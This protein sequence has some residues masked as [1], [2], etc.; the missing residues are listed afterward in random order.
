[1]ATE[2]AVSQKRA[3]ASRCLGAMG[4]RVLRAST[5]CFSTLVLASCLPGVGAQM[6]AGR[7][8]GDGQV[9]PQQGRVVIASSLNASPRAGAAAGVVEEKRTP[10]AGQGEPS[11]EATSDV[12]NEKIRRAFISVSSDGGTLPANSAASAVVT[13]SSSE[14]QQPAA[15]QHGNTRHVMGSSDTPP[16]P[17]AAAPAAAAAAGALAG[18]PP[19]VT[20]S[21]KTANQANPE[22]SK[23]LTNVMSQ[24]GAPICAPVCVCVCVIVCVRVWVLNPSIHEAINFYDSLYVI[25]SHRAEGTISGRQRPCIA[26]TCWQTPCT[27]CGFARDISLAR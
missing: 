21:A 22:A 1:M 5:L 4:R 17:V 14:L 11:R 12:V 10:L 20:A 3:R 6:L 23:N 9:A 24:I 15:E 7:P 8:P 27:W 13:T 16:P 26:S 19:G 18:A 2:A 25:Y